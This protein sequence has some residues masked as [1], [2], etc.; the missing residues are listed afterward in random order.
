MSSP[1]MVMDND[2]AVRGARLLASDIENSLGFPTQVNSEVTEEWLTFSER[3][4]RPAPT[5]LVGLS[6]PG[7][8][9]SVA[10]DPRDPRSTTAA[11]FAMMLARILQDDIQIHTREL[12]PKDP[13]TSGRALHP[14]ERGWQSLEYRAYLVPYGQLG[15][16]AMPS[17][18]RETS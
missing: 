8:G 18:S 5:S 16:G 2:E 17:L 13:T 12:W 15:P 9:S 7:V 4:G 6:V 3:T 11:E 14:T 1:N 10:L